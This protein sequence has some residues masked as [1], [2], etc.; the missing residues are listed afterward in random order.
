MRCMLAEVLSR[1]LKD[2][3]V[4]GRNHANLATLKKWEICVSKLLMSKKFI[5]LFG[6][7]GQPTDNDAPGPD[8]GFE[9]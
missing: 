2:E 6:R 3:G 1:I 7:I 4:V 8:G 9:A 5:A